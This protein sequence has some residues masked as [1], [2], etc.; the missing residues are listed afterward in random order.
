M[1]FSKCKARVSY[2][3]IVGPYLC[4]WGCW[5]FKDSTLCMNFGQTKGFCW[6]KGNCIGGTWITLDNC[7]LEELGSLS[8]Y[9]DAFPA[10]NSKG[11]RL[12]YNRHLLLTP[13]LLS[14]MTSA[15]V[16]CPPNLTCW[17]HSRVLW[18]PQAAQH[19]TLRRWVLLQLRYWVWNS[20]W[21]VLL[22]E[23]FIYKNFNICE[24]NI[25]NVK[26]ANVIG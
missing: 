18:L 19:S 20:A 9:L 4:R 12:A 17:V 3:L 1:T 7:S 15:C 23:E 5:S 26:V 25:L 21:N 16:L 14:V 13:N 22:F 6:H 11:L 10:L 2:C 8:R 24:N